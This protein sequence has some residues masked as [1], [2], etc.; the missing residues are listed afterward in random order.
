MKSNREDYLAFLLIEAM[1][2][3]QDAAKGT[4]DQDQFDFWLKRVKETI[5][6]G[7]DDQHTN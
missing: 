7:K 5:G 6:Y 2:F 4:L 1:A 3:I